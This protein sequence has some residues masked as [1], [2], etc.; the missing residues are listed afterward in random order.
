MWDLEFADDDTSINA[1]VLAVP[2]L[3]FYYLSISLS[4]IL[5][6]VLSFYKRT[7]TEIL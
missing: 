6:I 4:N 5:K 3:G 7:I 2:N 1:S